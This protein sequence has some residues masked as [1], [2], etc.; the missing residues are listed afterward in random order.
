MKK[1]LIA[2]LLFSMSAAYA[3]E[4]D[5]LLKKVDNL[6]AEYYAGRVDLETAKELCKKVFQYAY[7]HNI[8][9][10]LEKEQGGFRLVDKRICETDKYGEDATEMAVFF[11]WSAA[12]TIKSTKIEPHSSSEQRSMELAAE[13][14]CRRDS[15]LDILR[16]QGYNT[17]SIQ[18]TVSCS[19]TDR[20]C[21]VSIPVKKGTETSM[22]TA[23]CMME[24]GAIEEHTITRTDDAGTHTTTT[25]NGTIGAVSV[26]WD[27]LMSNIPNL[28]DFGYDCKPK[29]E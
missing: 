22:Y 21:I 10:W 11:A 24:P 1:L 2:L 16:R 5:E 17:Y 26:Y 12:D 15:Y 7:A 25:Y 9:I 20:R 8:E 18:S 14:K 4:P 19:Q 29:T 23:C 28:N 6:A 27:G 13:S 3:D